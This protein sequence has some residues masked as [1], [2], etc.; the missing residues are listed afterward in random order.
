MS[1]FTAERC[2]EDSGNISYSCLP[3][4][5]CNPDTPLTLYI[6]YEQPSP[7]IKCARL[8]VSPYRLSL[9]DEAD[10][11]LIAYSRG[12]STEIY[13][14]TTLNLAAWGREIALAFPSFEAMQ[15]FA[16]CLRNVT[17]QKA[18]L[19]EHPCAAFS[20]LKSTTLPGLST[21]EKCITPEVS[22]VDSL[23]GQPHGAATLEDAT[24]DADSPPPQEGA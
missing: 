1:L 20:I 8:N 10:D 6:A 15:H 11:S 17:I 12:L 19:A 9:R 24:S 13:F 23:T 21:L 5:T 16:S 3:K 2:C 22:V 14:D 18:S 7:K 4:L